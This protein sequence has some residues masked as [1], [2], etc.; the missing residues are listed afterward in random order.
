MKMSGIVDNI[1][2]AKVFNLPLGDA[3]KGLIVAGVGDTLGLLVTRYMPASTSAATQRMTRAGVI[4]LSAFA[5]QMKPV[6]NFIGKDA[7]DAGTLLLTADAIATVF[8]L[9]GKVRNLISKY[10]PKAPTTAPTTAPATTTAS[11]GMST[12]PLTGTVLR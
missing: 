8:D 1:P 3:A 5:L 4:G 11:A 2:N 10:L 6:R 9:R 7:A 12:S